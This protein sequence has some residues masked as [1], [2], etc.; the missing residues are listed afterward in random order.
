MMSLAGHRLI[1][2]VAARAFQ[3]GAEICALLT[4]DRPVDDAIAG[5]GVSLGLQVVRGSA[6][7][8]VDRT[9]QG[10]YETQA[11]HFLR[12]NG[13]SPFFEPL[14]ARIA[15]CHLED[16]CMISNLLTR[17]FPYGVAVEWVKAKF[18]ID[19]MSSVKKN[20]RE[21]VT[22]HL[23][24][25]LDGVKT[26]SLIQKSDDTKIKLAMDTPEDYVRL[27]H[28][29]GCNDPL[30]TPY[31]VIYGLPQPIISFVNI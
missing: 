3:V 4:S 6:I 23:Y 9:I 18:F 13:D 5:Y 24:R 7:D 15:M 26:L 31:W 2:I 16:V 30:T 22:Q 19:H 11:T 29:I 25:Q 10:I 27:V 1:D 20:E 21:H 14:F 28:K 8:L 17:R 12:L